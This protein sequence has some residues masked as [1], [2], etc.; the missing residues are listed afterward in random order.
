[1][2]LLL[3]AASCFASVAAACLPARLYT[4]RFLAAEQQYQ[5]YHLLL[6]EVSAYTSRLG[7]SAYRP[8][9]RPAGAPRSIACLL[10]ALVCTCCKCLLPRFLPFLANRNT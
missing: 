8:G 4:C 6:S 3:A 2:C 5:S 1:M 7:H 10:L 9:L